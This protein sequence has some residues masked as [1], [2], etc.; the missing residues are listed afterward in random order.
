MPSDV[1]AILSQSGFAIIDVLSVTDKSLSVDVSAGKPLMIDNDEE[2]RMF[3]CK[4]YTPHDAI[5]RILEF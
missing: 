4:K 5:F 2:V 3:E 1:S